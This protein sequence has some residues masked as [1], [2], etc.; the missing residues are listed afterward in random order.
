MNNATSTKK[1][2]QRTAV[3]TEKQSMSKTSKRKL[4]AD[5][6]R[7]PRK[8]ARK[9]EASTAPKARHTYRAPEGIRKSRRI[10]GR[11]ADS[12]ASPPSGQYARSNT[13]TEPPGARQDAS[14]VSSQHMDPTSATTPE[15]EQSE[16][17]PRDEEAEGLRGQVKSFLCALSITISL[18][19]MVRRLT[20]GY[21]NESQVV[22]ELRD[23]PDGVM[24][25]VD[26][27]HMMECDDTTHE[28]DLQDTYTRLEKTR[29]QLVRAKWG[30]NALMDPLRDLNAQYADSNKKLYDHVDIPREDARLSALPADFWVAYDRCHAARTAC[31]SLELEMHDA[32]QQ[33]EEIC[34]GPGMQIAQVVL[35]DGNDSTVTSTTTFQ[36]TPADAAKRIREFGNTAVALKRLEKPLNDAKDKQYHEETVLNKIAED[37]LIAAGFLETETGVQEVELSRQLKTTN[38]SG[39]R[40][41][42]P[43][44]NVRK[45]KRKG[46]EPVVMD[47]HKKDLASKVEFA[48]KRLKT[49]RHRL[50]DIRRNE[51]SDVGSMSSEAQGEERVRRMIRRTGKVREAQAE[52]KAIL[53]RAQDERAISESAQSSHFSNHP[54]DGYSELTLDEYGFP[55]REKKAAYVHDWIAN[56]NPP[57]PA[58]KLD[59]DEGK[60]VSDVKSMGYG[61]AA[62]WVDDSRRRALID[63]DERHRD[64]L[65]EAGPF[66]KAEND[67]HPKNKASRAEGDEID[68]TNNGIPKEL[69]VD[70]DGRQ[71]P[72]SPGI[73]RDGIE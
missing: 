63:D 43:T 22:N 32:R 24:D 26:Q 58:V 47:K 10:T 29:D 73:Q 15:V 33:Q 6:D 53:R 46:R 30:V 42:V 50:S 68:R 36:E 9:V 3:A 45:S 31:K 2:Q 4:E 25:L 60:W 1:V 19:R 67:F 27:I 12:S 20:N 11:A 59:A 62:E 64:Y 65:R 69:H 18:H 23:G 55:M 70:E 48:R 52:Y 54:S 34:H 28:E 44:T 40:Q 17:A 72:D 39:R 56:R 14:V 51:L 16:P 57:K 38:D 13:A 41:N 21:N 66:E 8:R 7:H 37:A 35:Q 5:T 49:C 71:D 61:E